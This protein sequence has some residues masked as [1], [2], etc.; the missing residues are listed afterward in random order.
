MLKC[1]LH[2]I[3]TCV[4][5][6]IFWLNV[7]QWWIIGRI[8]ASSFIHASELWTLWY[9][10]NKDHIPL[11]VLNSSKVVQ[12]IDKVGWWYM[13]HVDHCMLTEWCSI[14]WCLLSFIKSQYPI[15]MF[16]SSYFFVFKLMSLFVKLVF[17]YLLILF[18]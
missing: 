3:P 2:L 18:V 1:L 17:I 11:S 16:I 5:L 8:L 9:G 14:M 10:Q 12:C 15:L 6:C 13:Y 4:I 7:L